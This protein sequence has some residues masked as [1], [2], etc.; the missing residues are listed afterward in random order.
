MSG[1]AAG[2]TP[3]RQRPQRR[4]WGLPPATRPRVSAARGFSHR[5]AP[6]VAKPLSGCGTCRPSQPV[7]QVT[8]G[9]VVVRHPTGRQVAAVGFAPTVSGL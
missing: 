3:T 5:A 2:S 4:G 9:A 8:F 7:E 1:A 6:P